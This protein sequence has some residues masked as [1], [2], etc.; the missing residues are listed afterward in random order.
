[1]DMSLQ[2]QIRLFHMEETTPLQ[3]ELMA[4]YK[5]IRHRFVSNMEGILALHQIIRDLLNESQESERIIELKEMLGA[6]SRHLH[7]HFWEKRM[8]YKPRLLPNDYEIEEICSDVM[9][10][11]T[12]RQLRILELTVE[13]YKSIVD[14]KAN[15]YNEK[16]DAIEI[17]ASKFERRNRIRAL[18]L[19]PMPSPVNPVVEIR[20]IQR[21]LFALSVEGRFF[22]NHM[23]TDKAYLII[24]E[25]IENISNIGDDESPMLPVL[26]KLAELE[27]LPMD[28][29]L[30]QMVSDNLKKYGLHQISVEEAILA[31]QE[32]KNKLGATPGSVDSLNLGAYEQ[33]VDDRFLKA[34]AIQT[35]IECFLGTMDRED[36]LMFGNWLRTGEKPVRKIAFKGDGVTLFHAMKELLDH[37]FLVPMTP[38]SLIETIADVFVNEK[39]GLQKEFL[40]STVEQFFH[41]DSKTPFRILLKIV[42]D[43]IVPCRDKPPRKTAKKT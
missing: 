4:K 8:G 6:I 12:E 18:S 17:E 43:K 27:R 19:A 23:H 10:L 1:M 9:G 22:F 42:G 34:P 28:E 29:D 15:G 24:D 33:I 3:N 20:A 7:R 2:N 32:L 26:R 38:K 41:R 30:D 11:P 36:Y 25:L 13:E 5:A 35:V 16:L 21:E 39:N 40:V 37:N 31:L 14:P